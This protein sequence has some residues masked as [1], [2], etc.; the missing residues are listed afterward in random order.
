MRVEG[1]ILKKHGVVLV[2]CASVT[3]DAEFLGWKLFF[4]FIL[5][6]VG[7]KDFQHS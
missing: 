2:L 1:G 4:P 6:E 3:P 7:N 5:R